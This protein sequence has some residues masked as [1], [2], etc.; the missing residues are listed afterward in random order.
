MGRSPVIALDCLRGG[1]PPGR[2]EVED[3]GQEQVDGVEGS[4][5]GGECRIVGQNPGGEA[6]QGGGQQAEPDQVAG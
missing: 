6:A 4:D 5:G 1:A 3:G 2:V